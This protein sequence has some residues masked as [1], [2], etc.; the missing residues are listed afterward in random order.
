MTTRWQKSSF[1]SGN[2]GENCVEL[3]RLPGGRVLLRESTRP[4]TVLDGSRARG[5]ALL[6]AVKQ[7]RF[8]PLPLPRPFPHRPPP[9]SRTGR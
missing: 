7:E 3:A 8:A 5:A 2:G 1:S 9:L 4:G 6:A